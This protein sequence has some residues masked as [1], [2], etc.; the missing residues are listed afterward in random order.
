MAVEPKTILKEVLQH[1]GFET[2]IAEH[3]LEDGMML[4]EIQTDDAGRL[5]GRQGQTLG[6]KLPFG[7]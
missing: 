7:T 1:L 2:T 5:I 6:A 4:L 3:P